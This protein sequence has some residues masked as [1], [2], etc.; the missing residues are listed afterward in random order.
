MKI[1]PLNK[2]AKKSRQSSK[3]YHHWLVEDQPKKTGRLPQLNKKLKK[4]AIK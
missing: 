2:Q 3:A 4:R 1:K